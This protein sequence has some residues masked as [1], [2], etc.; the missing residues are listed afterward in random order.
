MQGGC[1]GGYKG[2]DNFLKTVYTKIR[3]GESELTG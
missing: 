3:Q 2:V 1:A